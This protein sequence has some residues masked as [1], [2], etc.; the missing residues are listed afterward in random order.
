MKLLCVIIPLTLIFTFTASAKNRVLQLDGQGDYVQLPSNIFNHLDEATIEGWVKWERIGYCS[1]PF[2]FGSGEKWRVMAVNNSNYSSDLQYFIYIDMKLY[3]IKVP[4]ILQLNQ[5]CHVVAVSGR[6]GMKLY[7]NG[8]LVGTHDYT[9]SFSSIPK[10]GD[11]GYKS[12]DFSYSGDDQTIN[13]GYFGKP[14]WSANDYFKGQLDEVRVWKVALTEEQIRAKMHQK[15]TGNENGLVGLWSFDSG[16]ARDLSQN[17]YDGFLNG[18]AYCVE[19]N[20]PTSSELVRP[21]I[22]SGVITDEAGGPLVGADVHLEQ[23]GKTIVRRITDD[24]GKYRIVFYPDRKPYDM[25]AIWN[26]K[27]NWQPGV[28]FSQGEHHTLDLTLKHAVSISGTLFAYDNTFHAGVSVQAVRIDKDEL[29]NELGKKRI[30]NRNNPQAAS[31]TI[32][33]LQSSIFNPQVVATTLSDENGRYRFINLKPGQYKVRCYTLDNYVYYGEE[34]R[35]RKTGNICFDFTSKSKQK[36]ES[37]KTSITHRTAIPGNPNGKNLHVEQNRTIS[38]ID[39]RFAPFKKGVWRTYTYLDGLASDKVNAI[40][41]DAKGFI[42]FG[43]SDGIS[44]YD[45]KTF[46]NFTRKDGLAL[47]GV[48]NFH[49][50]KDD[51]LWFGTRDSGFFRYDGKKF[52]NFTKEHGLLSNHVLS[53]Y[54]DSEGMLWIGTKDGL[55]CYDG[56][57]FV[58]FTTQDGLAQNYVQTIHQETNGVMWIGT[59]NGLSRH[60]GKQF[61]NF[62]TQDGLIDNNVRAI[63]Q[64]VNGIL[65]IGTDGGISHY[66]K[67]L[68]DVRR[69]NPRTNTK[70]RD[71]H[72]FV[73]FTTQDGLPD[74]SVFAIADDEDGSLWFGTDN[75]VSRYDGKGFINFTIQ[76]GLVYNKIRT[77]Y[78]DANGHLWFGAY[79]GGVYRYDSKTLVNFTTQD[80]LGD[81]RVAAI[82]EDDDGALWFGTDNGVSRYNGRTFINF[83][84]QDGLAYNPIRNIHRSDNGVLWFGTNGG[85]LSRYDGRRFETLNQ[86]DGLTYNKVNVI[87]ET[88]S[89]GDFG[90]GALWIGTRANG[91]SRLDIQKLT[92][93]TLTKEDGLLDCHVHAIHSDSDGILW[94][95]TDVGGISRYD[96]KR[97]VNLTVEDGLLSNKVLAIYRGADGMLWFGTEKGISRYDGQRFFNITKEDGLADNYIVTICD[98]SDGKLWFGTEEGGVSVYDGVTWMSLDTRDGLAANEIRAIY[99]DK[100]GVLWFGTSKGITRYRRNSSPP[101]VRVVS[102]QADKKYP[103]SGEFS[104]L[105]LANSATAIPPITAGNRVTIE[106]HAIDFKTHP[107][108]RQYQT[109]IYKSSIFNLQYSIFNYNPPTKATTFDWTPGKP[110]TYTFEVQAID[111]DL[112][113]SEPARVSLKIVS[114]WYLNGWIILPSGVGLLVL[115]L[116]STFFGLRYYAQ[117]R[118]S[119]QLRVRLLEQERQN[120]EAANQAKSIFLANMSHEI[121]TPLNAV[122]GYAYILKRKKN[123]PTDVKGA[124]KTIEE[125]G[126]HLLALINDILDISKI[127]AGQMELQETDFNLTALIHGLSVMFQ[128]RCEQKN[129][130][131]RVEWQD[132][133]EANGQGERLSH[134]TFHVSRPILVHGDENRLRQ[135]LMNLLSNAVKFTESGEVVLRITKLMNQPLHVSLFMFE[136]IDTGIGISPEDGATIFEPFAQSED[137]EKKGGTGLG[138]AIAKKSVELMRGELTFESTP[139]NGS[140]FF[141]TLPL[142]SATEGATP[143]SED[144][145][146]QVAQLAA[147]YQVKALVVDDNQENR[148]VLS[149]M[150]KDIGVTV[151][152]VENGQQALETVRVETPDIVFMDIWMPV[153]DG[154]EAT[155]RILEEFGE[156]RPKLVAVSASAL[157]HERQKYFEAGF[158]DFIPKPVDAQQVYEC[159]AT[160]LQ[161]EY[162]YDDSEMPQT[163]FEEIVLPEQLLLRLRRAA[164][165]W[166]VT[167]LEELLEEVCQMGEHGSLLAERLRELSRNFDMEGILDILGRPEK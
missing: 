30:E 85:G 147:G 93:Q 24:T 41:S 68:R 111:R 67:P 66:E 71:G 127:E 57:T 79:R 73:N 13:L 91:I 114:P 11:F 130:A 166:E 141:F 122:L 40:N 32:F 53:I 134:F 154:L 72:T 49:F 160:F 43:T 47:D 38:N 153:M 151:M 94:F 142:E 54:R 157:V 103:E 152:M 29:N 63:H 124:V 163:E 158:D 2:G 162:E 58:N 78:R 77:I 136:V 31:K 69:L 96:G 102:V 90:Y 39:F 135:V 27:G 5:W 46:V 150:L 26:E 15:L 60:D 19:A 165:F 140:R 87:H 133:K 155:R 12:G 164:E 9:G 139:Q 14:H 144:S 21:V 113:Y 167:E 56:K 117:R 104:V 18:G 126:N 16:D 101:V 55:S 146:R 156:E 129:L 128:L 98:S 95:G 44:R 84:T 48:T 125:S 137:G 115:L 99:E 35:S 65:W 33:N 62:T 148:D 108:K 107:E 3:L 36:H 123:L 112:N 82:A 42:W 74:N 120:A 59:Q 143:R 161:I 159:L 80:G 25:K 37:E 145:G 138:L 110:G 121:R 34:R 83:T 116:G 92:F 23:E 118:E 61:T 109:R 106:F 88:R 28:R 52:V 51:V 8:V 131:W 50:D 4:G 76:D 64:D 100:E 97:I 7:L 1:Q 81:N 17:G 20:L 70:L 86:E 22:L 89:L 45:G 149:Q 10:S 119:Q 75:G 132:G 105:S 6:N